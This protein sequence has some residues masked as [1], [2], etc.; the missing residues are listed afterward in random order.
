MSDDKKEPWLSFLALTTVIFAVCATLSTFKGGGY[1]TKSLIS[2]T[3]ASDQ[4]AFFQAKSIRESL[5][6]IEK[7]RL[8]L[9]LTLQPKL[10][11]EEGQTRYHAA[12]QSASD[13]IKKY[14]TEKDSIQIKAKSLEELRDDSQKHGKPFGLAVIFFQVAILLSSIAGLFKR[15]WLWWTSLP[16]GIVGLVYFAN[17]FF[18][19][20]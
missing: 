8:E 11:G 13:K 7:E 6:K 20:F 10:A 15:Q 3:Q 17:G 16:M 5:Y 2:Q 19:F 1:S 9:E 18:L 14:A 12:I 4:W